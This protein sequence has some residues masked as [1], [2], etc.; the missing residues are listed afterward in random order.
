MDQ[1]IPP[2]DIEKQADPTE[3]ASGTEGQ[4]VILDLKHAAA[5]GYDISPGSD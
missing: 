3:A 5:V 4:S 2:E 1:Y